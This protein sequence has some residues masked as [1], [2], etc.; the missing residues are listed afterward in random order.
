MAWAFEMTPEGV[1][2]TE[3]ADS[4]EARQAEPHRKVGRTLDYVIIGVLALALVLAVWRPW[5]PH[6]STPAT[7]S[8]A[9]GAGNVS[10]AS[11][12]PAELA[13]SASAATAS[14][15]IPAKSIAVLPLANDSGDKSQQYFSDGLS[16]NLI[17]ALSQFP[18]LKVI[19]RTSSFR[20]RHTTLS[21]A[22]IGREL[23]VAHLLEGSVQRAGDE[24]RISAELI[25]A[26]DGSTL[27][28]KHYDRP[29]THLFELQDTITQAVADALKAKLL[30]GRQAQAQGD[31]P[32]N[33][34]LDAYNAYLQGKAL[35]AHMNAKDLRAADAKFEQATRLDPDYA[36]AWARL[37]LSRA[38]DAGTYLDH[39]RARSEFEKAQA[40]AEK[41]VSL[42]PDR[43]AAHVALG[44]VLQNFRFDWKGAN[45][46]YR[47]AVR[48][49]PEDAEAR[50]ALAEMQ[51]AFGHLDRAIAMLRSSLRT[52]PL[53]A[54]MHM[55]LGTYLLGEG[56]LDA[57]AASFRR[58]RAL[59][60]T[61]IAPRLW[62]MNLLV[63]QGD[64]AQA[65]AEA[66]SLHKASVLWGDVMTALALQIGP[67]RSA[68]DAALKNII[69]TYANSSAY[70]IAEA[71][72]LRNNADQTFA[73]LDRAWANRDP[74]LQFLLYDNVLKPFRNEPRFAAF[75]RKIGLPPP[76]STATGTGP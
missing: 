21:S 37:A 14:S 50:A 30:P 75:C 53:N 36:Q 5:T 67:D 44:S 68:A 54:E 73:W 57:A 58:A 6:A 49:A 9:S 16:E 7:A 66:R 64:A 71:Y 18:G 60:P 2:R 22:R 69:R 70:Q 4:P 27:W 33:G 24:V 11:T 25:N 20:F 74:G 61:A 26:A 38:V 15:A 59:Q 35:Y 52:E 45:A 40:D 76:G 72:A 12:S 13:A 1:R 46:Q 8:T 10:E 48:L 41:A 19:G 56:R 23:G 47:Q 62:Q 31:R 55:R 51:A 32:P 43:A 29:Y 39:D 34:N 3:P 63:Q 17:I 42:A 65:L 28:S